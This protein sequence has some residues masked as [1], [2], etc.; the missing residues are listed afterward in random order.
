MKKMNYGHRWTDE[1]LKALMAS[2]AEGWPVD[3]IAGNLNVTRAAVM[4]MVLRLRANGIPLQ[5]RTA[6]HQAGRRNQPWTQ[7]EVEYL[8]RCREKQITSEQIAVDL[9]RSWNAVQNMIGKLRADGVP[10]K[11]LG[12]GVRK[13]WSAERIME[14]ALGRGLIAPPEPPQPLRLVEN[15]RD[16]A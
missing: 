1:E 12:C 13:L 2:W 3:I 6:G 11:M 4:K 7:E 16:A 15:D 14:A 10:V 5:R 8:V 9:G